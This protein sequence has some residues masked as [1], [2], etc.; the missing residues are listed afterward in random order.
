MSRVAQQWRSRPS[1]AMHQQAVT[2]PDETPAQ[3]ATNTPGR[4]EPDVNLTPKGSSSMTC[5][6]GSSNVD[7]LPEGS[8]PDG[9]MY[10]C[11]DCG[12]EW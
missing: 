12:A 10:R 8:T 11:R 3:T 1:G 9:A 4:Q 5:T 6:C 2:A 7:Q